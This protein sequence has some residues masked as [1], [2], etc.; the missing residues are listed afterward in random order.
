M[1][2][3]EL[4]PKQTK[5]IKKKIVIQ[6]KFSSSGLIKRLDMAKKRINDLKLGQKKFTKPESQREKYVQEE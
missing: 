2:I 6:M 4:K 3:L 5:I 1:E